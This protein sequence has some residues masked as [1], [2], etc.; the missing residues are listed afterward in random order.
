MSIKTLDKLTAEE[1]VLVAEYSEALGLNEQEALDM[2]IQEGSISANEESSVGY[3]PEGYEELKRYAI[4]A[5]SKQFK[6]NKALKKAGKEELYEDEVF[7]YGSKFKTNEDGSFNFDECT[8]TAVEGNPKVVVTKISYRGVRKN[9]DSA[10]NR[11]FETDFETSFGDNLYPSQQEQMIALGG[12]EKGNKLSDITANLKKTYHDGKNGKTYAKV[13]QD[14]KVSFRVYVFGLVEI[15]GEWKPFF[16]DVPN[17]IA[18]AGEPDMSIDAQYNQVAGMKSNKYFELQVTGQDAHENSIIQLVNVGKNEDY[19]AFAPTYLAASRSV[20]DFMKAQR[21][22]VS[23]PTSKPETKVTAPD[24]E[25]DDGDV[26][27][28]D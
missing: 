20:A 1:L 8:T 7:Y 5:K 10:T 26:W 22:S 17:R 19:K 2:A 23:K 27:G 28:E 9:F 12:T 3:K 18:N 21:E 13:P 25:E 11:G 16:I 15:A 6:L 24:L 14:L 4:H